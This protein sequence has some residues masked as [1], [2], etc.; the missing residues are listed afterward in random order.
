MFKAGYVG[1]YQLWEE[2]LINVSGLKKMGYKL[3]G[4]DQ[5]A[6]SANPLKKPKAGGHILSPLQ[7]I[8]MRP[9]KYYA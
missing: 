1:L 6:I 2:F 9:I 3:V 5:K 7:I 4:C 8:P